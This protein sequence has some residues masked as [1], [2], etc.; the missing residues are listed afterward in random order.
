[1]NPLNPM[2]PI[3][4]IKTTGIVL[5]RQVLVFVLVVLWVKHFGPRRV[6]ALYEFWSPDSFGTLVFTVVFWER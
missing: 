3:N 4:P 2:N 5:G 6:A 1:M